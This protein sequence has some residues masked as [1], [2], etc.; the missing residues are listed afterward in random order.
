MRSSFSVICVCTGG[1]AGTGAGA[2]TT[3]AGAGTGAWASAADGDAA[4]A[5]RVNRAGLRRIGGTMPRGSTPD[6]GQP[7]YVAGSGAAPVSSR[8]RR[9]ASSAASASTAMTDPTI[10]TGICQS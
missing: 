7:G 2:G 1:G 3:G 5:S 6:H 10:I 4:T 9:R 8:P